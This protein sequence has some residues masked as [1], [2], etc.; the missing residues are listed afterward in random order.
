MIVYY[1][2]NTFAIAGMSPKFD[3]NSKLPYI[4]TEDPVALRI[5]LGQE[6]LL[7]YLVVPRLGTNTGIIKLKTFVTANIISANEKIYKLAEKINGAEIT[8]K[9]NTASKKITFE[10]LENVLNW[11]REDS[12][13]SNRR[14]HLIACKN[15]DP[16]KPI[17]I[18]SFRSEEVKTFNE[19]TYTSDIHFCLYTVKIFGSYSYETTS[20]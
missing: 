12:F 5:F 20:I 1:D 11:W 16:F 7:N 3:I 17:W 18:K 8:I 9:N 4:E 14:L 19:I 15:N 13:Y 6:K 2:P 10:I